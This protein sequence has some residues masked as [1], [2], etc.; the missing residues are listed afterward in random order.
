MLTLT[1]TLTG[2]S[3]RRN[4]SMLTVSVWPPDTSP[5]TVSRVTYS[6]LSY[7]LM[8]LYNKTLTL[9][10]QCL[11]NNNSACLINLD[12]QCLYNNNSA[13]LINLDLQCLYNNNSA[14]LIMTLDLQ[15][16]YN[17]NSACLIM[18]LDLQCLYNNNSACL[19]NFGPVFPLFKTPSILR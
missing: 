3:T 5:I 14:C 17:N 13:C 12:L 19:I 9:D 16:L 10:L 7:L 8:A 2:N 1:I 4:K 11:Y 6:K 18:T 15:C